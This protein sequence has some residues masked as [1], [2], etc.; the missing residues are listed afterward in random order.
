MGFASQNT[1]ASQN[2]DEYDAFSP[3]IVFSIN[4]H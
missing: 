4:T 1:K 3:C 2:S